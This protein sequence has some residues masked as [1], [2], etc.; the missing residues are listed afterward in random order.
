MIRVCP[1]RT[2]DTVLVESRDERKDPNTAGGRR[3]KDDIKQ[4]TLFP[5]VTAPPETTKLPFSAGVSGT[6]LLP[7]L[8][9]C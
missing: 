8:L 6:A 9:L 7:L 5:S 3:G 1:Y 2:G 4:N